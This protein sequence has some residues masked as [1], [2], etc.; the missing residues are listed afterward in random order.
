MKSNLVHASLKLG[1]A[2]K[3]TEALNLQHTFTRRPFKV[4]FRQRMIIL[5]QIIYF[6]IYPEHF[7]M[8][9]SIKKQISRSPVGTGRVI[10]Q[11]RHATMINTMKNNLKQRGERACRTQT[12]IAKITLYTRQVKGFLQKTQKEGANLAKGLISTIIDIIHD[13]TIQ[14]ANFINQGPGPF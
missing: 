10:V 5:I 2:W 3:A 11:I 13:R 14:Q 1:R 4:F 7:K 12:I 8:I 6:A 9:P